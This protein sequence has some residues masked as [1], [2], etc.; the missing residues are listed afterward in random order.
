MFKRASVWDIPLV[1][2]RYGC[3]TDLGL[4]IQGYDVARELGVFVNTRGG[5]K[6]ESGYYPLD[7]SRLNAK[8]GVEFG[9]AVGN[10]PVPSVQSL[11]I[12]V[13]YMVGAADPP[14]MLNATLPSVIENFPGALEVVVVVKDAA[15]RRTFGRVLK[16]H[17]RRREG[18]GGLQDSPVP[19]PMR[20]V[21]EERLTEEEQAEDEAGGDVSGRKRRFPLLWADRYCSGRH[22]LHLTVDAVIM[23]EVTYDRMFH[24]LKPVVPFTRFRDGGER[25]PITCTGI[26]SQKRENKS[27]LRHDHFFLHVRASDAFNVEEA[28]RAYRVRE[29]NL[30]AS[31]FSFDAA[32]VD[33]LR[34]LP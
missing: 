6:C 29:G 13:V 31:S 4:A 1:K 22:I 33:P 3:Q 20:V 34:T 23:G 9:A 24:K 2:P 19:F 15:A 7:A 8:P 30:A 11:S 12:S 32:S 16:Y 10:P 5:V 14:W 26:F 27:E 21:M 18:N 28:E 17:E 25:L